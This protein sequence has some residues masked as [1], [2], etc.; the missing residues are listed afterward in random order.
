M[1]YNKYL[2]GPEK[3]AEILKG[4]EGIF[5]NEYRQLSTLGE[6][7]KYYLVKVKLSQRELARKIGISETSLSKWSNDLAIPSPSNLRKLEKALHVTLDPVYC[8]QDKNGSWTIGE[9]VG[10]WRA[11]NKTRT[12]PESDRGGGRVRQMYVRLS[13]TDEDLF[14]KRI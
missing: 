13:E 14:N 4:N 1:C 8:S 2:S 9:S 10:P 5:I 7:I 11:L 3:A 6:A 12:R